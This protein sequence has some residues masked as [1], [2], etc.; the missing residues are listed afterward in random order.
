MTPKHYDQLTKMHGQARVDE[1]MREVDR[2][3]MRRDALARAT[4]WALDKITED[5]N[6]RKTD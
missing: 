6:E 1:F 4:D 5:E 3:R 2:E